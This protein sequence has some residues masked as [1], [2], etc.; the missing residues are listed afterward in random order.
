MRYP[1]CTTLIDEETGV[2]LVYDFE[3]DLDIGMEPDGPDIYGLYV[4]GKPLH[5]SPD[6]L[7]Q[8]IVKRVISNAEKELRGSGS[9][10]LALFHE[11][12]F[13]TRK[14]R[15]A[16]EADRFYQILREERA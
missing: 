6:N 5:L 14:N 11:R 1:Y 9:V 2:T 13:D 4:E 10:L 16:Y 3:C 8:W 12:E 7:A 15:E